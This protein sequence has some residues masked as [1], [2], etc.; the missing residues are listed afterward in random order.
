MTPPN[1]SEVARKCA[2]DWREVNK[3]Y[4]PTEEHIKNL[5]ESIQLAITTATAP[6]EKEVDTL[7]TTLE[8]TQT[9][10]GICIKE[11][12]QLQARVKE[13]EGDKAELITRLNLRR[14]ELLEITDQYSEHVRSGNYQPIW[15]AIEA[16]AALPQ[17]EN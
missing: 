5:A 12:D 15:E 7:R 17:P 9:L 14:S 6:L 16:V 4:E 8:S 11:R 3:H 2:E 1:I 10:Y 13:L